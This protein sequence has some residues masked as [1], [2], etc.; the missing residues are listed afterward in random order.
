MNLVQNAFG[1]HEH[2]LSVRNRRVEL[3]SQNIANVDTPNYKARDIDFKRIIAGTQGVRVMAT[4][5]KHYEIA[6][7]EN[8]PDGLKFRVP[9]NAATD[10]NTVEMTIE[11]AQF[12]KATADYQATLMFLENRISGIRKALRGE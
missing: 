11:Q 3:I 12:S 1:I 8:T 6:H 5:D 4:N 9:F 2:A 10:G 7:L